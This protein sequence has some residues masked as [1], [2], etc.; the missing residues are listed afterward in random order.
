MPCDS[1]VDSGYIRPGTPAPSPPHPPPAPPPAPLPSGPCKDNADCQLNGACLNG[2]C[3]CDPAWTGE[4]CQRLDL[5]PASIDAGLQDPV[6]SSWGG[7]VLQNETDGTWVS[8]SRS[9]IHAPHEQRWGYVDRL[10]VVTAHV[11]G[12]HRTRLWT[13]GLAAQQRPRA[14]HVKL[15]RGTVHIPTLHQAALCPR[16]YDVF[17]MKCV[18]PQMTGNSNKDPLHAFL[19]KVGICLL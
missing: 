6:L 4:R 11:R 17:A 1:L 14:R 16:A 9:C 8:A 5:L 19:T 7:S 18:L 15:T 3:K 2:A 12:R 13:G 10:R